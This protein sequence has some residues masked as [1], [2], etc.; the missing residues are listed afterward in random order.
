[1]N[2]DDGIDI[3]YIQGLSNNHFDS[4]CCSCNRYPSNGIDF[5]SNKKH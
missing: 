2:N 4:K 3:V 5:E 1:M